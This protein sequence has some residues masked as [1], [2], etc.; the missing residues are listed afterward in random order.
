[1]VSGGVVAAIS[2]ATPSN[3]AA[4]VRVAAQG[5]RLPE[6]HPGGGVGAR[7]CA[8]LVGRDGRGRVA[9][10]PVAQQPG[11]GAHGV[12]VGR[13]RVRGEG[14]LGAGHG[15]VR[16]RHHQPVPVRRPGRQPADRGLEVAGGRHV[17]RAQR[18]VVGP[19]LEVGGA[20]IRAA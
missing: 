6:C 16:G 7:P 20:R 4:G 10:A 13:R 8:E 3:S 11:R 5:A 14:A 2:P 17:G 12:P 19:V 1:M 18:E 9:E 15:P